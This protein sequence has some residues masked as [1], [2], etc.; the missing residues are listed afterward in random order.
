MVGFLAQ[1]AA[2]ETPAILAEFRATPAR[3]PRTDPGHV[4]LRSPDLAASRRDRGESGTA[5]VRVGRAG[6][7]AAGPPARRAPA[8]GAGGGACTGRPGRHPVRGDRGRDVPAYPQEASDVW[9][10]FWQ[11]ADR[12]GAA[13]ARLSEE[14][15][16]SVE[17]MLATGRCIS[18][19]HRS[20]GQF[21]GRPPVSFVP[22]T[23]IAVQPGTGLA[24]RRRDPAAARLPRRRPRHD[25]RPPP[26]LTR[27]TDRD[28][29]FPYP[30]PGPL[31]QLAEQRTFNP[32]VPGS[33][34]GRPTLRTPVTCTFVFFK[35]VRVST[36]D[37]CV[38][39]GRSWAGE[40]SAGSPRRALDGHPFKGRRS[41]RRGVAAVGRGEPAGPF[42]ATTLAS[43][44]AKA[45]ARRG[46]GGGQCSVKPPA[47]PT[48]VRTQHLCDHLRKRG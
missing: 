6:R 9:R 18:A 8:R 37:R 24:G 46:S 28:S 16:D 29:G 20:V 1:G 36:V 26:N 39:R 13:P 42:R 15:A 48:L 45:L 5:V 3:R 2:A 7:P 30:A 27:H 14:T 32:R 34:P 22:I 44:D 41:P 38:L 33:I 43:A 40:K 23:D 12:R 17:E 11:I 4:V 31:A 19:T 25:R 47:Q 35:I 21:Y 10:A